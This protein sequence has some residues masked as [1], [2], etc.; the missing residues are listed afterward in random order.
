M[1][2]KVL[3][4][5]Q[6]QFVD[7]IELSIGEGIQRVRIVFGIYQS[8]DHR[9]IGDAIWCLEQLPF[10]AQLTQ[11]VQSNCK[12]FVGVSLL[13]EGIGELEDLEFGQE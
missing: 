10:L 1:R 7:G 11:Q 9:V 8:G 13:E 2:Q 6:K 5:M 4:E 12:V 3:I